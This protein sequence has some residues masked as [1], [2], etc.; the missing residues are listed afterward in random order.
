MAFY[1]KN[2][3]DKDSIGKDDENMAVEK[4]IRMLL[5]SNELSLARNILESLGEKYNHLLFE[6]EVQ[7]GNYKRALEIYNYLPKDKQQTYL[8][9][10][11]TIENDAD[12]VSEALEKVIKEYTSENYPIFVAEIQKLKRSYPQVV[13]V[14]ALELLAA[15][16]RNDKKKIK[17]LSEIL[18]QIDKTHPVLSRAKM[19]TAI[20]SFLGPAVLITLFV[21]VLSNLI[22]SIFSLTT[23][24]SVSTLILGKKID[25]LS[26]N[27]STFSSKTDQQIAKIVQSIDILKASL[28][29]VDK[30]VSSENTTTF[31][32][33]NDTTFEVL[34]DQIKFLADKIVQLEKEVK[35]INISKTTQN[36][37]NG[38][39]VYDKQSLSN[40]STSV[41][42]LKSQM[43]KML[44]KLN[45]IFGTIQIQSQ[46]KNYDLSFDELKKNTLSLVAK[47]ELISQKMF[48]IEKEIEKL[49]IQQYVTDGDSTQTSY[50]NFEKVES[51]EA[52]LVELKDQISKLISAKVD[53][54]DIETVKE[55]VELLSKKLNIALQ[56]I[57][58][59]PQQNTQTFQQASVDAEGRLKSMEANIS[60]IQQILKNMT[61]SENSIASKEISDIKESI[62]KLENTLSNLTKEITD[63]KAQVSKFTSQDVTIKNLQQSSIQT[64]TVQSTSDNQTAN[65]IG[66]LIRETKD[67]RELFL[68]GLRFYNN[69]Q[70]E[71]SNKILS[72]V[73]NQLE[74]IDVYF[75][76]DVYYYEIVS[77]FKLGNKDDALGIFQEYKKLYPTGQY[78]KELSS[79]FK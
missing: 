18:S 74:G 67:L 60:E 32:Q 35:A 59:I 53:A 21:I 56:G 14:I 65:D 19:K 36:I 61:S 51:I 1:D 71:E 76:E 13:E 41:A 62:S 49:K 57:S 70:Y 68:I 40:L 10:A 54:S 28:D 47:L 6:L 16:R 31:V 5:S 42:E 64:T 26:T 17:N 34:N 24:G 58:Q 37:Q 46:S 79:M 9:V 15:I 4:L 75:K 25:E 43:E 8:H 30:K 23:S 2:L 3:F 45:S 27:L 52:R 69:A 38:Q 7:A 20:K 33:N 63:I 11:Q 78:I 39:I 73:R 44:S 48:A 22:V 72:Y 77:K 55:Q 29:Y 66:K 12:N 50:Q